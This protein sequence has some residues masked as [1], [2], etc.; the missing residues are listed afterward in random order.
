MYRKTGETTIYSLVRKPTIFEP[1]EPSC[2]QESRRKTMCNVKNVCSKFHRKQHAL[3][4][5]EENKETKQ[6]TQKQNTCAN[7][8]NRFTVA[9]LFR[10]FVIRICNDVVQKRLDGLLL[11]PHFF[12]YKEKENVCVR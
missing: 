9:C 5:G 8:V 6:K 11:L 2:V 1:K 10:S 3:H 7:E 12:T 4:R